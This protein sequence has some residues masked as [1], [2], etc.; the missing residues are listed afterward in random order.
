M[1]GLREYQRRR[2]E[3]ADTV[4]AA[5]YIARGRG[6][7][8]T[9]QQARHLLARLAEDRFRLAVVGQFSRGK[10]TLMNALLG[11][12]YLPTGTQP[13]TSV[14][15][16][17]RYGSR[18]RAWFRRR[19]SDTPIEAPLSEVARYV[20]RSS[21]ERAELQITE[22]EVEI[23]AELLRLGVAFIDTPG[24]GTDVRAGTATTRRFL[25]EADAVI[26][27]TGFDQA[28]TDAEA[29]FLAEAARH[30]GKLFLVVNKRDL[31]SEEEAQEA[32]ESLRRLLRKD[33]RLGEPR[34]F[35][36]SALWA[37][38]TGADGEGG[39]LADSGVPAFERELVEFLTGDK[40]RLFLR[41]TAER[42]ARLVA[43]L[44]RDLALG[45]LDLDGGPAPARVAAQFDARMEEIRARQHAIGT[46]LE[47]RAGAVVPELLSAHAE[48]RRADLRAALEPCAAEALAGARTDTADRGYVRTV[49]DRLEEA[50][51]PVVD[52]WLSRHAAQTH[53][54]VLDAAGDEIGA[55]LQLC[56][57]PGLVGAEIAGLELPDDP[58]DLTGWSPDDVPAL[59]VPRIS[60]SVP[61][62]P[63]RWADQ[64]RFGR[65]DREHMRLSRALDEAID[66]T[67]RQAVQALHRMVRDW[68]DRLGEQAEHE[69]R[70][71]ADRF[72]HNLATRPEDEE[73][74]VLDTLADRLTT[75]TAV[76]ESWAPPTLSPADA[77]VAPVGAAAHA[78]RCPVCDQL[79]T[80]L[81]DLLRHTQFR[82][83]TREAD[84]A[85]HARTGGFCPQ[86]TWQ[87]AAMASPVGISA[88]YA[89]LT[90]HVADLIEAA[91]TPL[92]GPATDQ[93][94]PCPVCE[95][96]T[97]H[98]REAVADTV[99]AAASGRDTAV[100][101]LRHL[102]LALSTR[103]APEAAQALRQALATALH[104]NALDMRGLALKREALRGDLVT[105]EEARAYDEALR[106]LAGHRSLTAPPSG[107]GEAPS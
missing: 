49:R 44:R 2:L 82:L 5:L 27:V 42:A 76:L 79:Q 9:E 4:R 34:L 96:L 57:S 59:A 81:F 25:P 46:T 65:G 28:F 39:R 97:E 33:L 55:L 87:Y 17:V 86:H 74:A 91:G 71:A 29:A 8:H 64:W 78:Y 69:S 26:Y 58:A 7:A 35:A 50:G 103:P 14:V 53:E 21:T 104:R 95:A 3:L 99:R 24:A 106:L 13:M 1:N 93:R 56:R 89:Q 52:T 68:T 47:R 90:E 18:P 37:Q 41:G 11:G 85:E 32:Q 72:R 94:S 75:V 19:G 36:L 45:R 10:S 61:P 83:A 31:V 60:W 22:A 15:T 102:T 92:H 16:T 98:E 51:G 84:Q 73:L 40:S 67:D 77:T 100:L 6:D 63:F 105:S 66:T 12:P 20:A 107:P 48:A 101:C 23:P 43:G 62:A 88:G 80:R 30:A 38:Q 70:K 54:G